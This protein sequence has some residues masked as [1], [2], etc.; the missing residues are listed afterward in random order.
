MSDLDAIL[1]DPK[2]EQAM[3]ARCEEQGHQFEPV[4]VWSG[5]FPGPVHRRSYSVCA[6]C[7][8]RR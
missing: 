4:T 2:V 3:R 1:L 6:W 7:G 8:E 5:G